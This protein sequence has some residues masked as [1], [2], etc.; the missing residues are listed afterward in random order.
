MY[1]FRSFRLLYDKGNTAG[2]KCKEEAYYFIMLIVQEFL[3]IHNYFYFSFFAI[4][5]KTKGN[6]VCENE[7]L[8]SF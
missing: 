3:Y 2:I 1:L 6:K 5:Q 8:E 4:R 7:L